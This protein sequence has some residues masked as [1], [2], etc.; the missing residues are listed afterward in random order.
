MALHI[1]TSILYQKIYILKT[2]NENY[3]LNIDTT[4]IVIVL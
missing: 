4:E 1:T 2:H 3:N